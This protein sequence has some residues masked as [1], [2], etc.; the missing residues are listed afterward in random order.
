MIVRPGRLRWVHIDQ[1][2]DRILRRLEQSPDAR[3]RRVDGRLVLIARLT[4]I[5]CSRSQ[6]SAMSDDAARRS[7]IRC[8]LDQGA[9]PPARSM[10]EHS[11]ETKSQKP[12]LLQPVS[13]S[14][15][16]PDRTFFNKIK[17]CRRVATRYDKLAA[18]YLAFV[19]VASIRIWL[20]AN[21]SAP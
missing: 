1:N 20:R 6:A 21:E 14:R 3:M 2:D 17:Q 7:R 18:N 4:G 12:D 9:C 15:S 5:A 11:P 10:G 13:I 16:Q 8:R 19:K